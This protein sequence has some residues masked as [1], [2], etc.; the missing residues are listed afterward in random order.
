MIKTPNRGVGNLKS[1]LVSAHKMIQY[2]SSSQKKRKSGIR[3][4]KK[5][6]LPKAE[7]YILNERA[8][9]AVVIDSLPFNTFEKPGMKSFIEALKDGYSPPKRKA[10]GNSLKSQ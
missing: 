4:D 1:H 10:V 8:Y 7:T 5:T 2:M 3:N 9:E 6:K